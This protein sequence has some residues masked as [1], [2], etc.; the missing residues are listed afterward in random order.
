MFVNGLTNM[1]NARGLI[2]VDKKGG[3]VLFLNPHNYE[4][5]V[6]LDGFEKT[7]HELLVLP[8]TNRAYVPVFGD[9]IHGRNPICSACSILTTARFSKRS[10]SGRSARHIR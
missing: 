8:E 2:A 9:G 1:A 6:V 4:T 7:V 3:R 10:T 5:E